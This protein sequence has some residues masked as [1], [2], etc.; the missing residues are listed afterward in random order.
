[1]STKVYTG[2]ERNAWMREFDMCNGFA[3]VYLCECVCMMGVLEML[4]CGTM[5]SKVS[6]MH[7]C[8]LSLARSLFNPLNPWRYHHTLLSHSHD[9]Y[10][11][12]LKPNGRQFQFNVATQHFIT[13]HNGSS[14]KHSISSMAIRHSIDPLQQSVPICRFANISGSTRLTPWASHRKFLLE[15]DSFSCNSFLFLF[16]VVYCHLLFFICLPWRFRC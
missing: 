7:H 1:M 11:V 9:P 15:T 5:N 10:T 6:T 4:L 16:I 12:Q 13:A 8:H 3:S 2:I 14:S